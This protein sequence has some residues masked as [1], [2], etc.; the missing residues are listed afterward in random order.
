MKKRPFYIIL[1]VLCLFAAAQRA[2]AQCSICTR[3]AQQLGER[4]AKALN[5]GI[6]YLAM[7]PFAIFGVIGYRWWKSNSRQ[8]DID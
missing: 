1:M 7:A 8:N 4:P 3:T 5:A 2:G 6:I